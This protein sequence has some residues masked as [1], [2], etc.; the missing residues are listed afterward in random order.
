MWTAGADR[1][2]RTPKRS[3]RQHDSDCPITHGGY[4]TA[5]LG[6]EDIG[7]RLAIEPRVARNRDAA[8]T[9]PVRVKVSRGHQPVSG[10]VGPGN[11]GMRTRPAVVGIMAW[12]AWATDHARRGGPGRSRQ[13]TRASST[14]STVLIGIPAA[15]SSH[16]SNSGSSHSSS[17]SSSGPYR[18]EETAP[19][20]PAPF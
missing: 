15:K 17:N 3:V 8:H 2:P 12:I 5:G 18:G 6:E 1:T 16:S 11:A 10:Y 4:R 9:P 20:P 14:I 7:G 13:S 19:P